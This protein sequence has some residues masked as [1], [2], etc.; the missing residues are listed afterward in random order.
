MIFASHTSTR[1]YYL[2]ALQAPHPDTLYVSPPFKTV[3]GPWSIVVARLITGPQGEFAGLVIATLEPEDFRT[4]LNSVLFSQG[5]ESAL[6]HGTGLQFLQA[7]KRGE[8]MVQDL[9]QPGSMFSQH[10]DS[11]RATSIFSGQMKAGGET[12]MMAMHSIQPPQLHMDQPL[13]ATVSRDLDNIYAAWT[14]RSW[15]LS[16]FYAALLGSTS[17]LLY[18]AQAHRH[19]QRLAETQAQ[20]AIEAQQVQ[21]T[22]LKQLAEHDA[23]WRSIL[24]TGYQGIWEWDAQTEQIF[25]SPLWKKHLGYAA[26]ELGNDFRT[27]I[28]V[29]HPEDRAAVQKNFQ[30]Y[31]QGQRAIYENTHR[32]RCQDG[33]YLWVLDRGQII[34]RDAQGRMLR[35]VGIHI[36]ITSQREQQAQLNLLIAQRKQQEH[37]N[38]LAENIPGAL[39]QYLRHADGSSC[40][41]YTSPGMQ[42]LYEVTPQQ[43]HDDADLVMQRIH[44][45]D[46]DNVL[47][48]N[49]L[50]REK[51]TLWQ[52]EYRV[53]LPTHGVRWLA[54]RAHPQQ[55]DDGSM[56]WHGYIH[57][58]TE[59]KQLEQALR[60]AKETAE[61]ASLAKSHFVANMS[62]EIRTP[63]NAVLGLLQL[64]QQTPLDV[65]Q[66]G[67]TDK[68]QD[69]AHLLLDLL[70]DIL[71]FSKIEA[72][73][74]HIEHTVFHLDELLR[75]LANVLATTIGS[76]PLALSFELDP[77][78]PLA[79]CGDP[80]RLQQVLLNLCS[81]AIKFTPE[82]SVSIN[83]QQQQL[84]SARVLINFSVCD[85]GIGIPAERLETIFD[86]FTQADTSTTRRYGGTGLGLSI[87]HQLVQLMGGE[88]SVTST[89][90]QGSCFSFILPFALADSV[91]CAATSIPSRDAQT[92]AL[93]G[94]RILL[95]EDNPLNQQVAHELLTQAGA[96]VTIASD[97]AESI[98]LLR[99]APTSFDAILMD[100]QMPG[101]DGHA[102]TRMLR[103]ELHVTLPI[104][105]MTANVQ[106]S[107]HA[108]SL[109][110]GM[111][112]HLG[113]PIDM[114]TLIAVLLLHCAR[115]Q[116]LV[117][118]TPP[119]AAQ[120]T[121]APTQNT[122]TTPMP[123]TTSTPPTPASVDFDVPAA[124]D[125]LNDNHKLYAALV[126]QFAADHQDDIVKVRLAL[127]QQD[128]P[129]ALRLLHTLK[130]LAATLGANTLGSLAA[131][132]ESCLKNDP[133][134]DKLGS[135]LN[136]LEHQLANAISHLL[137]HAGRL[138]AAND[139]H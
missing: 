117:Q 79:L 75:K 83:V 27:W 18:F 74:M 81:N 53:I 124:L 46:V 4:L 115:P 26:E 118:P 63:M 34:E 30:K 133:A 134:A 70:N 48:T 33:S 121:P 85:S 55:L 1:S 44:P 137:E 61:T 20:Q 101:M 106:A 29:I 86:S 122:S 15:V 113:K 28:E 136:S 92:Q 60:L 41:P 100:I 13:I 135:L 8:S 131:N 71:D 52:C 97:G 88:L 39:F 22:L 49:A 114:H 80:L 56:L 102:T 12:R 112:E 59:S 95:V 10:R 119:A 105:A 111:N 84:E 24:D 43:L 109:A 104:I 37:L 3:L 98:A 62:H 123:A 93:H 77:E 64:L 31:F 69:A 11:Q 110:A 2:S 58:V 99:Q 17:I 67:Y 16:L 14:L 129:A 50:A 130:G 128:H 25:I 126:Q 35:M 47:A 68:A 90:G 108:A 82:G 87:S 91:S 116:S 107:D 127:Q 51:L 54:V 73:Q 19:R 78:L 42:A 72:G 36:D 103:Q 6:V 120:E 132:A 96:S 38:L 9:A 7:P 94:L 125:R 89:L 76:K 23:R 45:D 139:T 21:E 40:F 5:T 65:R 57:D 66:R 138:T 32:M